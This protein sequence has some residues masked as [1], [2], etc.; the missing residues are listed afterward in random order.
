MLKFL[1]H[2]VTIAVVCGSS[3]YDTP[4]PPKR[5]QRPGGHGID[6]PKNSKLPPIPTPS[7]TRAPGEQPIYFTRPIDF[8]YQ[9]SRDRNPDALF[10]LHFIPHSHDDVGWTKEV[11]EFYAGTANGFYHGAVQYIYDSVISALAEDATRR[12]VAVEQAYFQ[13]WWNEQTSTMKALVQSLVDNGQLEFTNSA[14]SM[15]DEACPTYI[16]MLEN[17]FVGQRLLYSQLGVIPN[18]TWQIDDFGH[19]SFQGSLSTPASGYGGIFWARLSDDDRATR[20]SN[21]TMEFIWKPSPSTGDSILTFAHVFRIHYSAPVGFCYDIGCNNVDKFVDDPTLENYNADQQLANFLQ[22]MNTTYAPAYRGSDIL[23]TFGDDF[24]HEQSHEYFKNLDK[25]M[26]Y[27]NVNTSIHGFHALYSTPSYY[28]NAKNNDPSIEFPEN[29][30]DFFPYEDGPDYL[31]AGYFTSRPGL[32]NFIRDTSSIYSTARQLQALIPDLRPNDVNNPMDNPLLVLEK[33]MGV[34]QHHDAITGTELD[35]VATDYTQRLSGGRIN[36]FTI[37]NN[38]LLEITG[39]NESTF[40]NCDFTNVTICPIL[41]TSNY[42]GNYVLNIWNPTSYPLT[43]YPIRIPIALPGTYTSASVTDAATGTTLIAQFVPMSAADLALRQINN[44]NTSTNLQW[45]AWV[46]SVTSIPGMGFT[47]FI[48]QPVNNLDDA[49][50]TFFSEVISIT[51]GDKN[52]LND[53]QVSNGIVNLTFSTT[54]GLLTSYSNPGNNLLNIPLSQDYAWYNGSQDNNYRFGP[55]QN[56]NNASDFPPPFVLG[57]VGNLTFITGPV[58]NEARQTFVFWIT[59]VIRLWEN[60]PAVQFEWTVGEIDASDNLNRDVIIRYNIS[61]W[62][63]QGAFRTDS[64][65]RDMQPR[66]Y[67]QRPTYNATTYNPIS[68]NYYPVGCAIDMQDTNT[69]AVLTVVTDRAL[70]GGSINQGSVELMVHRR[71][72][73]CQLCWLDDT[74]TLRGTHWLSIDNSTNNAAVSRVRLASRAL[75]RPTS[76]YTT[77]TLAP[78]QY[79][80]HYKSYY[81]ALNTNIPSNV[82]LVTAHALSTNTILVR[83]AHLYEVTDASPS[84][85]GSSTVSLGNLLVDNNGGKVM[86]VTEMTMIGTQ[87]LM[88]A[89]S[90]TY[91]REN[92]PAVTLPIVP[93]APQGPDFNITLSSMQIRTFLLE[94]E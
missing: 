56:P 27:I 8:E 47:T 19:S 35:G 64:N 94:I 89:P 61:S 78:S 7:T 50:Y 20:V 39:F 30:Y 23:V 33:N 76:M 3:L 92:Q 22:L 43:N 2:P 49:P 51:V 82:A 12:F 57:P 59:Q 68:A 21:Q 46:S 16:D 86:R 60:E 72:V 28:L 90:F 87:P 17:T 45:L 74:S 88:N 34:V 69:N 32:K 81:T 38:G 10:N 80:A 62:N 83:L 71:L 40:I 11:D 15:H 24:E 54:T 29:T 42:N 93:I 52:I 58:I 53:Q 48:I 13:L 66:V 1:L 36:A 55:Y 5:P 77:T 14:Y 31:W 4:V 9:T 6:L 84:M 44:G 79:M 67:N 63:N 70:G 26:H 37:I 41:Q 25:L 73:T 65:C 75:F 85:Y 18:T 91:R